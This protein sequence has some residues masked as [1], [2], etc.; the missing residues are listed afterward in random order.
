MPYIPA[1][2]LVAEH[3]RNLRAAHVDGLML[4]WTLGGYP[5]PNLEAMAEVLAGG[6]L[7][8][9][10]ERRFG[11]TL[12][13]AVMAA[14]DGCS[15]AF[16]EFPYDGGVVYNAPL[17]TGP[18]NLLWG[19]PTGYAATMVGFPYDHL[20]GWRSLYPPA[21]FIAQ[22]D[23]VAAGFATAAE[24]LGRAV[25]VAATEAPYRHAARSES[26]VM[27]AAGL[28]WQSA[29]DQARFVVARGQLTWASTADAAR[30]LLAELERL[31]EAERV[32]AHALHALQSRDSRL[33]F[34]ASNH[35]F[36]VPMDL[37]EKVLNC[38]DLRDRWLPAQRLRF[39]L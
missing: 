30:P 34:E 33:G 19:E 4:G 29:A 13:P 26:R 18:A 1:L 22:L 38:C 3:A 5:S 25:E 32:S 16:R 10:A 12:A 2:K 21:V 9:V 37:A 7:A 20:D 35:Y 24:R 39:G 23:K 15:E 17:Q 31:I 8:T 28:H 27:A 36:Y 11:P 6:E 14:W